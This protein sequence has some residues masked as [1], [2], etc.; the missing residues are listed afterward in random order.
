MS[1]FTPSQ[2][3][4]PLDNN[5]H[6][7]SFSLN[8]NDIN[9]MPKLSNELSFMEDNNSQTDDYNV[10]INKVNI[11]NA[12]YEAFGNNNNVDLD[13]DDIIEEYDNC[14]IEI[15]QSQINL[16]SNQQKKLGRKREDSEL[17]GE[18]NA[19]S[20]D[21]MI[22]KYKIYNIETIRIKINSEL[23]KTPISIEIEGKKY[24]VN[25][26]LKINQEFAKNITVNEMRKF[27]NSDLKSI[28]SIDIS[29]LYKNYPK[30]YNQLA[31]QKL[32]EENK[33]NVTCILNKNVL[34]CFKYFRKDKDVFFNQDYYC[35]KGIEKRFE[36]LPQ[37]LRNKKFNEGYINKFI[38]LIKDYEN[39]IERK[40]PRRARTNNETKDISY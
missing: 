4:S 8:S 30:N 23:K 12:I 21:N 22:R 33:T 36:N 27:F 5:D 15:N 7:P 19:L 11:D 29:D 1:S 6:E 20:E 17:P 28:F 35:L 40:S 10:G 38:E 26:L 24:K 32:Y 37:H 34:D 31:I 2:I 3:Y 39:I 14:V 25:Q 18:H 9:Y 16:N 13:N